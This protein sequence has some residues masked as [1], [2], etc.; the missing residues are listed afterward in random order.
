MLR[1]DILFDFLRNFLLRSLKIAMQLQELFPSGNILHNNKTVFIYF[2]RGA[3]TG[4][5]DN[6][7]WLW[8]EPVGTLQRGQAF[9]Q[10]KWES[11]VWCFVL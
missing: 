3:G 2:C 8:S 4:M 6:R 5:G 7:Y 1:K 9:A 10:T 11:P